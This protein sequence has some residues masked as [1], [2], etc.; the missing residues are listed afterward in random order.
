MSFQFGS[1]T[2]DIENPFKREGML[3]LISGTFISVTSVISVLLM[4]KQIIDHAALSSWVHLILS[5]LFLSLGVSH[6]VRGLMK[7]F[8]FYIG[9]DVP[10]SLCKNQTKSEKHSLE[11][12]VVYK[13]SEL[14]QMMAGRK[15]ITFLEPITLLDRML[16]SVFPKL[17]FLPYSMRNFLHIV[18][19]NTG[20]ALLWLGVYILSLVSGFLGLTSITQTALGQWLGVVLLLVCLGIWLFNAPT[21]QK[22]NNHQLIFGK[23]RNVYLVSIFSLV[24]PTIG[25]ML[26]RRD[27]TIPEAPIQPTLPLI[28]LFLLQIAVLVC[29]ILI[30]KRRAEMYDPLTEVSEFREH[31]QENVH[32]QDFF[33][34]LDMEMANL[35]YMEYP[36]RVYR[37]LAPKLNMEGSMDKGSFRGDT[38]QETQPVY[39]PIPYP[40]LLQNMRLWISV[41]GH[42]AV[43]CASLLLFFYSANAAEY[44]LGIFFK[45]V[46]YPLNLWLFGTSAII[47]AHLYWSEMHFTSY[48][49][50]F[51]GEGTYTESKFSVGMA[52]TDSTRSENT[53]VRSS[54]SPWLYATK[55]VSS[56]LV[57]SGA[58]NMSSP[59]Y[60]LSMH[61][62]DDLLAH[63]VQQIRSF[64]DER[65]VI[66]VS[67]S[68]KDNEAIQRIYSV[69]EAAPTKEKLLDLGASARRESLKTPEDDSGSGNKE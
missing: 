20:L 52:I 49:I 18:T 22:I 47:L 63:L 28:I 11:R 21:F 41:G 43:V 58:G 17:L 55:L 65:Q 15:N 34:S 66:A 67:T 62:A 54:F 56:T 4:K 19:E 31:W 51:Q 61:K 48:L 25:E 30:S 27:V 57:G 33:R 10:V 68:G 2:P 9:R 35:R 32:P 8:R 13:A 12:N 59:R 39:E 1:N 69:N 6:I 45:E 44:S 24:L 16:Y 64:V 7:V 42:I 36:N 50:Q 53:I 60:I 38:I 37:E 40:K 29:A 3:Y 5:L 23:R 26:I 14:D 46:F